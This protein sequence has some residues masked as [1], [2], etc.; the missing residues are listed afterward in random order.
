[1]HNNQHII[2]LCNNA[3]E[4]TRELIPPEV[5]TEAYDYINRYSEWG[6]GIEALIDGLTDLEIQIS[7]DQFSLIEAATAAME[8]GNSTRISYL[9]DHN[10]IT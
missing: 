1:M 6:V 9:R 5:Y 8:W 2:D 4:A 10:V 7:S 3:L